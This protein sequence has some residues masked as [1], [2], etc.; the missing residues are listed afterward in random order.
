MG[1]DIQQW[2]T[3][4][5]IPGD[6]FEATYDV[7]YDNL[8]ARG[9]LPK[10]LY[11]W[12]GKKP[13]MDQLW[14]AMGWT[15]TQ[16]C[17]TGDIRDI[18]SVHSKWCGQSTLL[19]K[20]APFV[21]DG[22]CVTFLGEDDE[23]WRYDFAAGAMTTVRLGTDHPMSFDSEGGE[24]CDGYPPCGQCRVCNWGEADEEKD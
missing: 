15:Y 3:R 12:A 21:L 7:L 9:L 8:A 11:D 2:Y 19:A 4:F 20:V 5:T 17:A 18:V 6:M 22:S 14:A 16:D 23:A 10:P 13:G 24:V 1:Y